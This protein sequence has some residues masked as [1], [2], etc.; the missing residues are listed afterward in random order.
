MLNAEV[1]VEVNEN[2]QTSHLLQ[3][4]A[5][6]IQH[7]FVVAIAVTGAAATT[8]LLSV[9][10]LPAHIAGRFTELSLCRQAA[11]GSFSV[12]YR[13]SHT[14]FLVAPKVDEPREIIQIG[15]EPGRI[16]RPYAFDL[17]AD[18]SFVV[19]DAPGGRGRVQFFTSSGSRLGGFALPGREASLVTFDGLVISGLG[20][21]VY[22]GRSIFVSRPESGSLVTELG[23]DGVSARTF[24]ELRA[25]GHEQERDLHLALNSG[26]IVINPEGGFYFVFVAGVPTFRRYHASGAL[27]FERHIEGTELDDYM[28]NRPTTWPRRKTADGEIPVVRPAVRA[29]AAD[30]SGA[31]WVSGCPLHLR[32]RPHGR[33]TTR[34]AVPGRRHHG[35]E[36]PVVHATGR[37]LAT[38]GCFLFNTNR[39]WPSLPWQRSSLCG[40]PS[41]SEP[42]AVASS[43]S[44]RLGRTARAGPQ[45]GRHCGVSPL[46]RLRSGRRRVPGRLDV[47]R[48]R[49]GLGFRCARPHGEHAR[50]ASPLPPF[51]NRSSR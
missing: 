34:R 44:R 22:N 33:Q 45:A 7:F 11:D 40:Q 10:G 12:F 19:A 9:G 21:L 50:S 49:H 28:R 25:T 29:A 24:G 47:E 16:L 48:P 1:N 2:S 42:D 26:L 37:L 18:S 51:A 8:T 27:M 15:A 4:S 30:P 13:R 5:F 46:A 6:G 43:A 39:C 36:R 17:A 14:V 32:V 35:P 31:L 41:R 3:H 20:S 38:P 23:V